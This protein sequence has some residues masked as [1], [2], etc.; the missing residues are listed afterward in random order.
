MC[1]TCGCDAHHHHEHVEV[2][3]RVVRL[4]ER[5]LAENEAIA[6]ETRVRLG[7][8][9]VTMINLI[10]G[11]G[12]GK[13]T[14]IEAT[15]RAVGSTVPLAVIEGDQATD[16]DA[17]RVRSA[18]APVHQINT[19]AGCHLDARMVARALAALAPPPRSIVF[20]ENVGNLVCPALF[21][22]GELAKVVVISVADGEDK[23]LKYPHVVRAAELL[24]VSKADLVPHL[25]IDVDAYRRHAHA[26][27]PTARTVVLSATV[28]GGMDAWLAWLE[29]RSHSATHR[30]A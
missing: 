10:G 12:A 19:G 5:L 8:L 1:R 13:T 17:Q 16:N 27:N 3:R 4:E 15:I 23:P 25:A 20:V 24:L 29:E 28:G 11:P 30:R 21:D 26:V 9:G 14:L 6:A 22:L 7:E 2:E 18:G